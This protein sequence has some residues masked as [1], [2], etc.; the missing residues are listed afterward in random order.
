MK[1]ESYMIRFHYML[2]VDG[3]EEAKNF[4]TFGF[5]PNDEDVEVKEFGVRL[6]CDEDIQE[7]AESSMLHCLPTPTTHGGMFKI[8]GNS[9]HLEWSWIH[10]SIVKISWPFQKKKRHLGKRISEQIGEFLGANDGPPSPYKLPSSAR[11][12]GKTA[13]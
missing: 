3:W 6:I 11:M 10:C 4:V 1:D 2:G 9:S 13:A 5:E 12:S 8:S 7:G